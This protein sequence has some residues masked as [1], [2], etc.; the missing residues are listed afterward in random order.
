MIH[1]LT[2]TQL[3]V[4]ANALSE[5]VAEQRDRQSGRIED[6]FEAA[7][8]ACVPPCAIYYLAYRLS[9]RFH[10]VPWQR[11]VRRSLTPLTIGLVVAAGYVMARAA[12]LGWATAFVTAAAVG[13]ILGTRLNPLLA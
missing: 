6:Q 8:I 12:D 9:H 7:L 1:W 10:D 4:S 5:A 11:L 2:S 3:R 13:P